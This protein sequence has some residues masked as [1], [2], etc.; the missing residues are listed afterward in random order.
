[1]RE[2]TTGGARERHVTSV[3]CLRC[4]PHS[5]LQ[6]TFKR[7][8][9]KLNGLIRLNLPFTLIAMSLK[10]DLLGSTNTLHL[11]VPESSGCAFV[12]FRI[13]CTLFADKFLLTVTRLSGTATYDSPSSSCFSHFS[14]HTVAPSHSHVTSPLCPC[15]TYIDLFG[16]KTKCLG[17][18]AAEYVQES[19][20]LTWIK[21]T[22]SKLKQQQKSKR[23]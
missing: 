9:R 11:Y 4:A 1:M 13:A 22:W 10:S 12:M 14:L 18:S 5:F 16:I 23:K 20:I 15:V 17:S 8:L 3:T 6:N 7:L 21:R 2:R 19:G